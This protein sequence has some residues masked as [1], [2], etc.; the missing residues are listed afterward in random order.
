MLSQRRIR[1]LN[2]LPWLLLLTGAVTWLG[3]INCW[4]IPPL[5]STLTT[6]ARIAHTLLGFGLLM[7]FGSVYWHSK[8]HWQ[9]SSNSK[10]TTGLLL[11]TILAMMIMGGLMLLYSSEENHTLALWLHA[12][13]SA[14]V[15]LMLMIH[16]RLL[17]RP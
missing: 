4:D 9:R 14:M 11:W 17:N 15:M 8:A 6:P 3:D 5:T 10:R 7:L 1:A 2:G 12:G 13:S 16:R